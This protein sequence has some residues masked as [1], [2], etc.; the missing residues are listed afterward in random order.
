MFF[1]QDHLNHRTDYLKEEWSPHIFSLPTRTLDKV[2]KRYSTLL[3]LIAREDLVEKIFA[4][5][6]LLAA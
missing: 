2:P 5:A 3:M 6:I 4:I 1:A